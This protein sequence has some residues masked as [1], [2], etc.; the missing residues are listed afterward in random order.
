MEMRGKRVFYL[1]LL[2]LLLFS[3]AGCKPN[4]PDPWE[5]KVTSADL[6]VLGTIVAEEF[7][8][9]NAVYSLVVDKAIKGETDIQT[10]RFSKFIFTT[11]KYRYKISDKV[12][13]CL[14]KNSD[15]RYE[16]IQ[17]GD[18]WIYGTKSGSLVSDTS[19]DQILC[20][21]IRIM[22]EHKIAISLPPDEIKRIEKLKCPPPTIKRE[23]YQ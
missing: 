13:V 21:V 6:I 8:D 22:K 1:F 2:L 9:I 16:Y 7:E 20:R 14:R 5:E 17:D 19:L 11:G 23:Y 12:L 3:I 10:V 15:T 18:L 4:P